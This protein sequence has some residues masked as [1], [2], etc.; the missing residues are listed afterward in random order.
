MDGDGLVASVEG[1]DTQNVPLEILLVGDAQ[2]PGEPVP[3][4]GA[5]LGLGRDPS[6]SIVIRSWRA[7]KQHAS[8]RPVGDRWFLRDLG[9]LMGT[10]VNGE[11]VS[12]YGPLQAGDVL[13]IAGH[14]LLVRARACR[15][16]EQGEALALWGLDMASVDAEPAAGTDR[17]VRAPVVEITRRA[18]EPVASS[19][20]GGSMPSIDELPCPQQTPARVGANVIALRQPAEQPM[21]RTQRFAQLQALLIRAF[22]ASV[23]LQRTRWNE[24]H[25]DVVRAEAR[26][27]ITR[28]AAE[29]AGEWTEDER[30]R[31]IDVTV[32]EAV[33]LGVLEEMLADP[34][35]SEIM[36]NKADEIFVERGG[37]IE[38]SPFAF[39]DE[40]SVRAVIERIVAPIGRRIDESSPMVDARLPDG[41]RVN[42]VLPPVALRGAS[43]TIR[44]FSRRALTPADYLAYGSASPQMI[45]FLERCVQARRNVIVSGGTGSGKTT[46]LNLL[47]AWI[48]L[49]ERLVSIEDAAELRLVHPNRV[50]LEARPANAE[51]QGAIAIRDLVRN[52]LRMRP[53]RIIVGECRGSEALDMLQAMNTGHE[54]SMTT[55][56]A[57]SPRDVFSRLEVMVMMAGFDIPVQAIRE[58]V[59]SAIDLIVHQAR[60]P[61]G[62]RRIV[63]IS[64]VCGLESGT[65]QS[66]T[67]F[68]WDRQGEGGRYVATGLVPKF[69]EALRDE[70]LGCDLAWFEN[71][72]R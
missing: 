45:A 15:A 50:A 26:A 24:V 71:H 7:A 16:Q 46:L 47:S 38:R 51:G 39:S 30:Q 41:S 48:P 54:G 28:L 2:S 65:V 61:D 44:R 23:D 69:D 32:A 27:Q 21:L 35:V 19:D 60:G 13:E 11:R 25:D 5:L 64:E 62:R 56:H 33:G 31:L 72:A 29:H 66:Q 58:Q 18:W 34:H 67:L 22:R 37:H 9:S 55:I 3:L 63:A 4:Q 52:A 59:A 40:A 43:M 6:N 8:L 53:D 10:L 42:A 57:N 12:D 36:V 68:R 14:R 70:G 20:A 1:A 17:S 49:R